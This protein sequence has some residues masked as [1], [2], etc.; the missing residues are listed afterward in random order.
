[1]PLKLQMPNFSCPALLWWIFPLNWALT[2]NTALRS[3]APAI[4]GP[5]QHRG[6]TGGK[7]ESWPAQRDHWMTAKTQSP[8]GSGGF[9]ICWNVW[10]HFIETI[11]LSA[12]CETGPF[13]LQLP[14]LWCKAPV[15]SLAAQQWLSPLPCPC[16]SWQ[17][18][19]K[20]AFQFK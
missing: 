12:F 20:E 19:L 15:A 6:L 8:G 4:V 14:H 7:A 5:V 17:S 10:K 3:Q 18:L 9:L 16:L 13:S 2:W 11:V 1:M